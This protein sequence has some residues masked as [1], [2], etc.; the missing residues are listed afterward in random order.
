MADSLPPV[1][2][3][4]DELTI[5]ELA[6]RVGMTVRNIRAHQ[7]RGLLH[8]PRIVGRTGLYG[9]S[10]VERLDRVRVLQDEGL[11][12]AAIARLFDDDPLAAVAT[13]AFTDVAPEYRDAGELQGAL[14]LDADDPIGERAE[15]MG[16]ISVDDDGRVRVELP[17]L[18]TVAEQL[19]R[20]QVPLA[21][22]LDV[23]E[24][25]QE[26]SA[27]V[28]AA[29][30]HLA[31]RHII[32]GVLEASG[33]DLDELTAAVER[34]QVQASVALEATFNRAMADEIRAYLSPIR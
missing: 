34:L 18:I 2:E 16:L 27:A 23:V 22:M 32:T 9:P 6:A 11:N 24:V 1:P 17:R 26:S 5:D 33:G 10:H 4:D 8:P 13:R 25:L 30:M 3:A 19:A 29:F 28:A 12:L 7:S 14:G 21:A 15:A 20:Q 31:D